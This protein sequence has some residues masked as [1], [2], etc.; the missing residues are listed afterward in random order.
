M[1]QKKSN[2]PRSQYY[3]II[4]NGIFRIFMSFSLL[5]MGIAALYTVVA[6]LYDA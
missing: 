6:L 3:F 1:C 4:E 2:D 5:A